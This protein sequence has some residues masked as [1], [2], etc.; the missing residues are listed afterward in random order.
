MNARRR[1][2]LGLGLVVVA[3]MC[4]VPPWERT[5]SEPSTPLERTP[6]RYAPVFSPPL[7]AARGAGYGIRLDLGRLSL[8]LMAVGAVCGAVMLALGGRGT[9][10]GA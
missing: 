1:V 8:Q 3:V 2:I 6:L 7:G 10:G 4:V 5:F 9:S